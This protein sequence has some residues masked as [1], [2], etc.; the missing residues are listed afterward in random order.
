MSG[1]F[2]ISDKKPVRHFQIGGSLFTHKANWDHIGKV[3][4]EKQRR[5]K[6]PLSE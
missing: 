4:A 1:L 2:K 5:L 6:I 3:L